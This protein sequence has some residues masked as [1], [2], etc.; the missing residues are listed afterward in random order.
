MNNSL[1]EQDWVEAAADRIAE[2]LMLFLQTS[3]NDVVAIIR[4]HA[5]AEIDE[6]KERIR[7]QAET[8]QRYQ[9]NPE[10]EDAGNRE[11]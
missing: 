7:N 9:T 6:L 8:I 3:R 5:A 4:E 2:R 10:N 11:T 1:P